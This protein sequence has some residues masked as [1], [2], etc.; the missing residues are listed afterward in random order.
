MI[1]LYGVTIL[2]VILNI[3]DFVSSYGKLALEANPVVNGVWMMVLVKVVAIVMIILMFYQLKSRKTKEN[4]RFLFSSFMMFLTLILTFV[5]ISNFQVTGEQVTEREI[6]IEELEQQGQQD[7]ILQLE[8]EQTN[9]YLNFM[10]L[11]FYYP[12]IGSFLSF[13][14]YR[15]TRNFN[16]KH[17]LQDQQTQQL[18]E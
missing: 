17:A 7:I 5:V 3:L 18:K 2:L 14:L 16:P 4:V 1:W 10:L 11:T 13:L 15:H 9:F 6:K 8:K 12:L